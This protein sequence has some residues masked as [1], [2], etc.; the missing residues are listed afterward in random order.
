MERKVIATRSQPSC[1]KRCVKRK[2]DAG[3]GH[4]TSVQA[5]REPPYPREGRG[6]SCTGRIGLDSKVRGGTHQL[7]RGRSREG[8]ITCR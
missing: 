8:G 4:C 1:V 5:R 3:G 2:W 6:L 7:S